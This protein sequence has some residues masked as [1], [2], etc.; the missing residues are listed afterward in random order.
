[1]LLKPVAGEL[2]DRRLAIVPDGALGYIPF[3]VLPEPGQSNPLLGRHEVVELPSASVLAAERRELARRPPAGKLAIVI[4]DPIF[5][6]DDPRVARSGGKV[7]AT[8]PAASDRRG[9]GS[10]SLLLNRLHFSRQ[11]AQAIASL[12]PPGAVTTRLDFAADRDLVL[13]GGLRD[14]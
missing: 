12:A 10:D 4:A 1:M 11:E 14:F 9:D 5:Q 6:P 2:G 8:V 3:D 7:P 13:S